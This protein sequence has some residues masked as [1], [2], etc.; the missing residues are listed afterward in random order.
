MASLVIKAEN[1]NLPD[2]FADR[3]KGGKIELIETKDG[4]LIKPIKGDPI[5]EL[6]GFLKGTS[7]ITAKYL[8]QKKQGK[9]LE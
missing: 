7:F 1:L 4:K 8:L 2:H 5:R 6:K 3:F 9:G